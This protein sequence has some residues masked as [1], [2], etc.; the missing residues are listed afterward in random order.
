MRK[1]FALI[2]LSLAALCCTVSVNAMV[3]PDNEIWYTSMDGKAVQPFSDYFDGNTIISN[4]Y[5]NGMGVLKFEYPVSKIGVSA[6]SECT[7]LTSVTI[8]GA[9]TTIDDF[10][11]LGCSYLASVT[12]P[13]SV[14]SIGEK[15]FYSC[16][17][18]SRVDFAPGSGLM[19]IGV[20]AFCYTAF[21]LIDIPASVINIGDYAFASCNDLK[22]VIANWTTGTGIPEI[23]VKVFDRPSLAGIYL[24]VPKG[25]ELEYGLADVWKDFQIKQ[26][27]YCQI[28]YTSND[29]NEVEINESADFGASMLYNSC[30]D[31][32]NGT[33]MFDGPVTCIGASAF[34]NCLNL[35]SITIP[36]TATSIGENA[37][38]GCA[39]LSNLTFGPESQLK[40]IG[41][42]AFS[43]TDITSIEIPASVTAIG[44]SAFK[45]CSQLEAVTVSW[46]EA[47]QI[48]EL[49]PDVFDGLLLSGLYLN[50]PAGTEDL[51]WAANVW[52]SFSFS[53]LS[54][55]RIVYTT[56]DN[57]SIDMDQS[58]SG[59]FGATVLSD[60]YKNGYGVIQFDGPVTKIGDEAFKQCET[61]TSITVPNT[62][63]EIGYRAFT[64]CS[65]L[66]SI[67]I[68]GSV[69][70]IGFNAFYDCPSLSEVVFASDSKLEKIGEMA[71][72]ETAVTTIDIPASVT[73]IDSKAFA[74]GNLKYVYANWTE[75]SKIPDI[76]ADVFKSGISLFVPAGTEEIYGAAS[77]WKDFSLKNQSNCQIIYQSSDGNTVTP[78][79]S[80]AFGAA[81]ISNTYLDGKGFLRFD[82]PVTCIGDDAFNF[83][84][85]LTSV[86]I[87]GTVTSIGEYAFNG[88]GLTSVNIPGSVTS[89]GEC[90][91]MGCADM[92][93][94]IIPSSVTSIGEAAFL[95]CRSLPVENNLRYAGDCYLV[96]AADKT[97]SSYSIKDG[98]KWIGG[99]AFQE[100]ASLKSI[101]IPASVNIIESR[102]FRD[103]SNLEIVICESNTPPVMLE[104]NA[105]IG[106]SK[107]KIYV[108]SVDDYKNSTNW[109]SYRDIIFPIDINTLI[110]DAQAQIEDA[111]ESAVGITSEDNQTIETLLG[112]I[113]S[114]DLD[115][116][117]EIINARETAIAIITLRTDKNNAIAAIETQMQGVDG[118]TEADLQTIADCISVINAA[119]EASDIDTQ[120]N[121]ALGIISMQKTRNDVLASIDAALQGV[122]GLTEADLQ[123][124]S[125]CIDAINDATDASTI[126][127]QKDKALGIISLQKAKND[128]YGTIDSMVDGVSDAAILA[129]ADGYKDEISR[130]TTL[131][132][133]TDIMSRTADLETSLNYY[134]AG[135]AAGRVEALS[136][137]PTE[138]TAGPAVKITK[139]EKSIM[140]IN[141]DKVEFLNIAE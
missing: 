132:Q 37:F 58:P 70:E 52:D 5:E 82:G 113:G 25:M 4:T 104:G 107:L 63:T 41:K 85:T 39:F 6:F 17:S 84:P 112:I 64:Y 50:V 38:F 3:Q 137:L 141:P 30:D 29:G 120:K 61:L 83:C 108:P 118:L 66:A 79:V 62:V 86:T 110:A 67:T 119:T 45:A 11:F 78:Y 27:S 114:S 88:C 99:L 105:F 77:V 10:A 136:G 47:S 115:H 32:G 101:T 89:I 94:A 74:C 19:D 7:G 116:V 23:N 75:A 21:P 65:E 48:P 128:A 127:T 139:G 134:N 46:T 56:S 125:D 1:E 43:E 138:G 71:F 57:S 53:K 18:L 8:P 51:Y 42:G 12:I 102:A 33:I 9:V 135:K 31:N 26:R 69:T 124:I 20:S 90:A 34:G 54:D 81:I 2:L 123:A 140:L 131:E 68:P 103:C 35:E 92:T 93:S 55:Y 109:E 40:T 117:S 24:L 14:T 44:E 121:R 60:T 15:A 130:A 36:G 106:C 59:I 72:C 126:D 122:D 100:C 96:G 133:V 16:Y 76:G 91:F 111:L 80:D 28:Q 87:P 129:I 13:S 22:I 98:T 73:A 95:N 49:N 97:L